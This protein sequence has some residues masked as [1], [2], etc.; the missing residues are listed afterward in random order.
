MMLSGTVSITNSPLMEHVH[1]NRLLPIVSRGRGNVHKTMR[2]YQ[3]EV[4]ITF[5]DV[6]EIAGWYIWIQD[7]RSPVALK[8]IYIGQTATLNARLRAWFDDNWII[9]WAAH[10]GAACVNEAV[11]QNRHSKEE[12]TEAAKMHP[13]THIIWLANE[14]L[15][16]KELGGV[17]R[18][19]IRRYRP[20]LNKPP[21]VGLNP[22]PALVPEAIQYLDHELSAIHCTVAPVR[23]MPI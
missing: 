7:R 2:D 23:P 13:V 11:K 20:G 18:E 21:V 22:Y 4:K 9:P 19:L 16:N 5:M 8:Y 17:E 6:P 14:W 10:Y 12:I 15:S 1:Q 3:R